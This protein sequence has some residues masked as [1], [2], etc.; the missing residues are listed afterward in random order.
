MRALTSAGNR[1]GSITSPHCRLCSS[2]GTPEY[3][4][5][6]DQIQFSGLPFRRLNDDAQSERS[7]LE[8]PFF[9]T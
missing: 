5:A 3:S 1:T 6:L 8:R 4:A 9:S 7:R 2:G